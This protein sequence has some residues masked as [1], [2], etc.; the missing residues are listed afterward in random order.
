[1]C[2]EEFRLI[3]EYAADS[4]GLIL[5]DGKDRYLSDMLRPRLVELHLQ[6]YAAYYSYLKFSRDSDAEQRTFISLITNNETYFYREAPQLRTFAD[7]VLPAMKEKK[8][9]SGDRRVR[10]VSAGCSSGEEVY[11]LAMLLVES[12]SFLW[13]WDVTV[14]GIDLDERVLGKAR[15]GV[16]SGRAFQC[17]PESFQ[18]RYFRKVEDGFAVKDVLRKVT[19]FVQGNLL[20][21]DRTEIGED[22]DIIFCR[23]VLIYFNDATIKR[24]VEGFARILSRDGLLFLGHSESL[25]RITNHYLPLRFPGGIIYRVRE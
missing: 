19:R 7:E 8:V 16:Y 15:D 21:L 14:T 12:G 25:A 5:D 24:V 6:S 2:P 13:D 4:F 10:I 9:L 18:E 22:V 11:T 3:Q 23:N 1:M 20:N 17:L